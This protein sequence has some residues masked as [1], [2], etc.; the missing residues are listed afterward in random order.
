MKLI[1][2]PLYQHSCIASFTDSFSQF[3][4]LTRFLQYYIQNEDEE[5][6]MDIF[7]TTQIYSLIKM[8]IPIKD[9]YVKI[10]Y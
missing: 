9:I 3:N 10:G 8:N 6:F 1:E 7:I 2:I 4:S 5:Y